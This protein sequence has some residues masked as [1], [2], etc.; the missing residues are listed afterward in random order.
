ML[1]AKLKK[2]FPVIFIST[3]IIL[4]FYKL[5][6]PDPSI[7]ITPDYGRSDSWHFSIANKY[8]YS[9]E[10][11]RNRIPIWNPQIGTGFPTLAEGQTAIFFI[12]NLILFRLL[13]F[14]YAYNMTLILSFITAGIGTYLFCRSLD[15]TK[16]ASTFAGL[17]FP[18]G[19]F[20]VFHVQHHNLL[21]TATLLPLLFW[22]ANEFLEK[23]KVLYLLALSLVI[24]QQ[25]FAGFPQLTFYSLFFLLTFFLTKTYLQKSLKPKLIIFL[26]LS[27]TLG[28]TIAAI[29]LLP[30]YEFLRI[31]NRDLKP[32]QIIQ[33]FPYKFKNL[34][35]LLDPFIWGSPENGTY[36]RWT[37][38][39]W[40]I[41]WESS[42]YV[43]LIPLAL[44]LALIISTFLK[45][46]KNKKLV[47]N[48]TFILILSLLLSLGMSAP[49][50]PIYSIPPFSLFRVPSRFLLFSSF[51]IVILA[52][53]YLNKIAMRRP[54]LAIIIIIASTLNLFF[55]LYSYNPT[56]KAK[57]WL[58][59]PI[60]ANWL[61]ENN[62][63][64]I[65]SVGQATPWT[66]YF[67]AN[68]W[69]NQEYYYVARNSLDQNSNLIFGINQ[70]SA[71]ESIQ[72]KRTAYFETQIKKDIT[73]TEKTA[74]IS[75]KIA[76]I[77]AASNVSH[78]ISPFEID[79][80]W[81][82]KKTDSESFDNTSF[83]I[84]EN[85]LIPRR[86]FITD[87]YKNATSIPSILEIYNSEDFDPE[88]QLI[89][90]D[91][92]YKNNINTKNWS[93]KT[94]RETSTEIELDVSLRGDGFLVSADT[95][96]PGWKAYV[97]DKEVSLMPANINKRAIF[98]K[99]GDQKVKMIYK[100]SSY[101]HGQIISS[102]SLMLLTVL[103][104]NFRKYKIN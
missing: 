48:F 26:L 66:N 70:L 43:G 22:A 84:Y 23:R 3:I 68:G 103:F 41:F 2:L 96:Y 9:Q 13:P 47:I 98:L 91:T 11:K 45:K 55:Y 80:E 15:L 52:A 56:G 27:I 24:S 101:K 34:A 72:T 21:Q 17:I 99:N 85:K 82:Q 88:N 18:L 6:L 25:I 69:T 7:F 64:R 38:G 81:F 42:A 8:Y 61:R 76:S 54:I 59:V 16:L 104:I 51:A 90:E 36:P 78:V 20:F 4:F 39:T 92:S 12:S 87:S 44:S 37:P 62:A 86:F 49:L 33:Q 14:L 28:F 83:H 95:Y 75:K 10:L 57:N 63:K 5:F 58:S 102:I 53:I 35:Q 97:N 31:S 46:H 79:S 30:S 73:F 65:Y 77:L 93:V 50:H 1:R 89:I 71:F 100:P 29:Q 32:Q 60:N 40:G 74:K 67:I 19:G 94:I